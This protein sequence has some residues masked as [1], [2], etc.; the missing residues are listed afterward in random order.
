MAFRVRTVLH[1][2]IRIRWLSSA[3][4]YRIALHHTPCSIVRYRTHII[5][6]LYHI[7]VHRAPTASYW[8]H[9]LSYCPLLVSVVFYR[10]GTISHCTV[11]I[12]YSVAQFSYCT[13]VQCT[14]TVSYCVVNLTFHVITSCFVL[15]RT[16]TV[17]CCT[18]LGEIHL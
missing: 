12:R 5:S 2:T 15:Y 16:V 1:F 3:Y 4:L 8:P 18:V 9:P 6:Y 11:P 17:S 10:T 14:H 7:I 13:V